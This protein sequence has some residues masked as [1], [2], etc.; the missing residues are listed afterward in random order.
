LAEADYSE[1][2][3]NMSSTEIVTAFPLVED[4]LASHKDALG[5][6]FVAY[7]N[8]VTRVLHFLFAIAP[9]LRESEEQVLIAAAFHDLG[10][11]TARTFDYLDPSS[12]LA[13]EYLVARGLE[14][15][16]PEVDLIIQ[17]HHKFRS[18]RGPFSLSV[19]SFRRAD[20]VDLSLGLIGFGLSSRLIQSVRA[21][22]PN[23]H[24][25]ARLIGFAGRH[26]L[27][28]PLRPLPMVRW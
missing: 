2:A 26:F 4:I 23:A 3:A 13:H 10:I 18:Y 16:W 21:A 24:Y 8:H 9:Q 7:R 22:L 6:D 27:R 1:E 15:H 5:P 25:H 19:E 12:R 17:Q 28:S 20:L 14:P 11:W